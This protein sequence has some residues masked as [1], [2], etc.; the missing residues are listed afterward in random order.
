M[1]QIGKDR[2]VFRLENFQTKILSET[3]NQFSRELR[4]L[5]TQT[6]SQEISIKIYNLYHCKQ[7]SQLQKFQIQKNIELLQKIYDPFRE[8]S[9]NILI[10][11][12]LHFLVLSS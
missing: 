2:T 7:S 1:I 11:I 8:S 12:S 4:T 5:N 10:A 6:S 9:I 3:F